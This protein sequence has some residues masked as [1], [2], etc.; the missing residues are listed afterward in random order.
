MD[1]A[2]SWHLATATVATVAVLLQLVLVIRGGL[3]LDETDPPGPTERVVRFFGYFTVLSNILVAYVAWSLAVGRAPDR[4][5]W[6]VLRL[7]S[8]VAI[9]VTGVVHWFLLRPILQLEGADRVADTLLHV[10]VPVLAVTGWVLFG[11]RHRVRRSDVLPALAFPLLW[12]AYTLVRGWA[13]GF[14]PYPFI[15]VDR[16][17]LGRTL[18]NCTAIAVLFL[19]LAALALWAD[20]RLSRD[21]ATMSA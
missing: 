13:S 9:A 7:D 16:I 6:R 5:W 3:V 20:R 11:P 14:Y 17:G 10:V 18:V 12:L 19:A 2:R 8:V 4:R 21:R 15:D 1:R